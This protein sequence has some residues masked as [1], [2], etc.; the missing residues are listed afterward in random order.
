P[1][2][3]EPYTD[4]FAEL[5][6]VRAFLESYPDAQPGFVDVY[7]PGF[8][9]MD[10]NI[11]VELAVSH[12]P[13]SFE[14]DLIKVTCYTLDGDRLKTKYSVIEPFLTKPYCE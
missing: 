8:T 10:G 6:E 2:G 4:V 7:V 9:A 13:G 5:D 11:R 3:F 12:E 1:D 14:P